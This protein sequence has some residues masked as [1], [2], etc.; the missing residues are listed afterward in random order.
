ML[1]STLIVV[2][3]EFGR[4]PNVNL[5]YGRDHWSAAWSVVMAGAKTPRGAAYGKTNDRGTEVLDGQCDAAELFH[6]YLAA[7][8]VDSS[9]SF[10]LEG[11]EFPIADPAAKPI[12]ALIS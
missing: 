7:V 3:S 2:L 10:D 8:G 12:K 11:R 4:T 5:Y 1:D 9:G 6:T